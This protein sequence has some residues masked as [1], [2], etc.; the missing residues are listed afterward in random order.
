MKPDIQLVSVEQSAH[1]IRLARDYFFFPPYLDVT[2]TKADLFVESCSDHYSII[3]CDIYGEHG[4]PGCLTDPVFHERLSMLMKR[5]G[6]VVF[7]TLIDSEEELLEILL[8]L[9][10][11][12]PWVSVLD[13]PRLHNV[14]LFACNEEPPGPEKLNERAVQVEAELGISLCT[15]MPRLVLLPRSNA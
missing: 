4:Q 12:F 8:P 5:D 9:R 7:N 14:L 11:F 10:L 15:Y 3:F 13:F 1:V 2:C 6:V